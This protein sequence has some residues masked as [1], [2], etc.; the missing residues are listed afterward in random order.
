M[1][2]NAAIWLVED[3]SEADMNFQIAFGIFCFF[4]LMVITAWSWEV[5]NFRSVKSGNGELLCGM[6]PPNKTLNDVGTRTQCMSAC[7]QV[8]P[9]PCQAYNYWK[10]AK[11]CQHF[12][13]I[14]CS[15]EVEQ[16]CVNYQVNIA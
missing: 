13:Y 12:H 14:P 11:L 16:N 3:E 4:L 2:L 9:T 1:L 5:S 8:C 15:Y 10:T 6:S 7:L